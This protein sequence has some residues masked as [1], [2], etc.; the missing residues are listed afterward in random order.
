MFQA[1][2]NFSER[3]LFEKNEPKLDATV[4]AGLLSP[5]MDTTAASK[6]YEKQFEGERLN[7]NQIWI[8]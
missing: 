7:G 3:E 1:Y 2:L 4:Y 6:K 5:S 8:K